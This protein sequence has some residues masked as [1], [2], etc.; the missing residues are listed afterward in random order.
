MARV[1]ALEQAKQL[2][3]P[4]RKSAELVSG[5]MGAQSTTMRLVEIA[6][7]K[8]G[9]PVRRPHYFD[10]FEECI[11]VLSGEGCAETDS[12]N[13]DLKAGDVILVPAG[14]KHVTRNIG[15][16]P[17]RLLCFFPVSDISKGH[18]QT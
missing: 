11:Y 15:T 4:G 18:R 8:A 5:E 7:P 10:G 16:Q 12:G 13:Y 1:Y 14:E 17:L 3:L 2:D 9:D 6:V